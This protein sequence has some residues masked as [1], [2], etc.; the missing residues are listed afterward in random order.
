MKVL[1]VGATGRTGRELLK[2]TLAAGHEVTAL[3]RDPS[4][5]NDVTGVRVAKGDVLEAASLSSAVAGQ[6]AVLNALGPTKTSPPGIRT[7]AVRNI[8]AAMKEHGVRRLVTL[9]AFGAG[10]SQGEGGFMYS[11]VIAK[12]FLKKSLAD[13]TGSEDE[14]RN[15]GLDWTIVRPTRLTDGPASGS[16]DVIFKGG[17]ASS[18]ISR[19][20]T[21]AFM[22][23]QLG[24]Q[25]YVG[26]APG[27]TN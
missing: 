16:Y 27:I 13:Q 19:A 6:D 20:D 1:I 10:D 9:S 23:A 22:L 26:K 18:K 11:K 7:T 8:V 2:Q 17:G 5:L 3:A 21:A 24:D 4:K 12:L 14:A 15:S 25:T